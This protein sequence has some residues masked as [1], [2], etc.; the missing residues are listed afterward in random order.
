MRKIHVLF[1]LSFL[2]LISCKRQPETYAIKANIK[3][4]P[5]NK[6]YLL[7]VYGDTYTVVDSAMRNN[8]IEFCFKMRKNYQPGFYKFSFSK[9]PSS[10]SGDITL[11]YNNES[12]EFSTSFGLPADSIK[13][14]KSTQNKAYYEFLKL[15]NRINRQSMTLSDITNVFPKND[16]FYGFIEKRYNELE[17]E[18]TTFIKKISKQK[19]S[20]LYNVIHA[21]A[22]PTLRLDMNRYERINFLKIHFFEKIDFSDTLL[23][24]TNIFT[25]KAFGYLQLYVNPQLSKHLQ[26]IEYIKATDIIFNYASVNDKARTQIADYLARGFEQMEMDSALFHIYDKFIEPFSCENTTLHD[27]IKTRIESEKNIALERLSRI[28]H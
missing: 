11:I 21:M 8:N 6:A 17:Q 25:S 28:Y 4:S 3:F 13:F 14:I 10:N 22:L 5:V 9:F 16:P 7:S 15:E 20:F 27:R 12:T 24:N 2:F 26:E 23:L 18:K 19:N 1:L